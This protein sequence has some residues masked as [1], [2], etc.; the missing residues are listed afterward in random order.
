MIKAFELR[1]YPN[2]EQ[3][4][5]MTNTFGVCRFVHNRIISMKKELW[6]DYKLSFT[7][8]L[9]SFKEEWPWIVHIMIL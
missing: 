3:Q 5:I 6:E 2:K 7:P 4:K 1:I 8:N 9:K